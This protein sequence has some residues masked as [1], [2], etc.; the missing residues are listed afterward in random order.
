M[1]YTFY[2]N[3]PNQISIFAE[4]YLQNYN[5]TF[6]RILEDT[7]ISDRRKILAQEK[8]TKL[9]TFWNNVPEQLKN[10]ISQNDSMQELYYTFRIPKKTRGFR[11]INAPC[12]FLKEWQTKITNLLQKD[13]Q[14]ATHNAAFAYVKNRS[15]KDA[16]EKHQE[17]QSKWF[18]K[19]DIKDFFPSC[20]K[21]LVYNKLINIY[22]LA[23]FSENGKQ[24]LKN[25]IHI[26]CLNGKLPQG[27]PASPYLSNIIFTDFDYRIS[28]RLQLDS[29]AGQY[30]KYTRY[31]DDILISARKT[32]NWTEYQNT[33]QTILGEEFKLK[34]EKTRY[35]SNAGRNWNLGLMLNK[36][37]KITTGH[38]NKQNLKAQLH[39]FIIAY[40]EAQFY[41]IP[42]TQHLQGVLNYAKQIEP[43]YINYLIQHY[44]R[45]FN[46]D[47]LEAIKYCLKRH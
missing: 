7:E 23:L 5:E 18:L 32:F 21:E 26:C 8:E 46:C 6:T 40:K 20:T 4:H 10:L 13:L 29:T 47:L 15:I 42:E 16:L 43:D 14:I 11:E 27:S 9:L 45:K 12:E 34:T 44:S 30:F 1:Y 35:G 37:N 31:A 38:V 24:I 33:I 41:S 22:P 19:L 36:D 25:I 28:L 3:R 17:N 39:H 2:Q